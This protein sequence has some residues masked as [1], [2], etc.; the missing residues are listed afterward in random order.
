MQSF[1]EGNSQMLRRQ[2]ARIEEDKKAIMRLVERYYQA[3]E[4]VI[5]EVQTQTQ[6]VEEKLH[7]LQKGSIKTLIFYYSGEIPLDVPELEF[8][9]LADRMTALLSNQSPSPIPAQ[10]AQRS[11]TL[12]TATTQTD[13]KTEQKSEAK[14]NTHTQEGKLDSISVT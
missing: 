2:Q 6:Q 7:K 8:D 14:F 13:V 10:G 9:T 1:I 12:T 11:T 5:R 3:A 4:Q